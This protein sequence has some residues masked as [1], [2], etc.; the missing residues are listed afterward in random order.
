MA[1]TLLNCEVILSQEIG[2]WWEGTTTAATDAVTVVD[3]GLIRFPDDWI[4]DFSYDMITSGSRNE[5]ERKISTSS[6]VSV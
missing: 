1:I 3:T 5:E 6:S 4:T 2:D